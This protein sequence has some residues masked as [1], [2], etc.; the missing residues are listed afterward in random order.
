LIGA[1]SKSFGSHSK[2][3]ELNRF[4]ISNGFEWDRFTP[5]RIVS[6]VVCLNVSRCNSIQVEPLDSG[7]EEWNERTTVYDK[8]RV[9]RVESATEPRVSE[10]TDAIHQMQ[11]RTNSSKRFDDHRACDDIATELGRLGEPPAGCRVGG[12]DS[13]RLH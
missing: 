8:K 7:N 5:F 11:T 12:D 4:S 13:V 1:G 2:V 10:V 9:F 6:W 3:C